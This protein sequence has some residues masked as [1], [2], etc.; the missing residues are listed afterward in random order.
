MP[1]K[2]EEAHEN[3]SKGKPDDSGEKDRKKI[4][5]IGNHK[6]ND[7]GG[8]RIKRISVRLAAVKDNAVEQAREGALFASALDHYK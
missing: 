2:L 1:D 3:R 6:I 8:L 4:K 5:Y 7:H